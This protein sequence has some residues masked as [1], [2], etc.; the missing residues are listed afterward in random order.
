VLFSAGALASV[1]T[2]ASVR[3]GTA[4]MKRPSKLTLVQLFVLT[5]LAIAL[6][7]TTTFYSVLEWSR[8]SIVEQSDRLRDADARRIGSRV[9]A[10]LGV[11]AAA[12]EDV[13]SAIRLGALRTDDAAGVENRLFSELLAHPTLSDVA[14]THA[15]LLGRGPG[16]D[17]R[18]S[19]D[20]RWQTSVFRV[21]ADPASEI[22][23]R[24]ISM[25]Q[26]RFVADARRRARGAGLLGAPWKREPV[27]IDPTTHP[28]FETTVSQPLYG[29]SIWS[30]LS[31]SELDSTLPM[32]ERRVIV[33]VQKA[34]E[35]VPGHFVGVMRVGLLTQTIDNL[36]RIDT[37]ESQRVFLCDLKGRLVAR[38]DVVDAVQP[39]GD[40]LRVVSRRLPPETAAALESLRLLGLSEARPERSERLVVGGAPFLVTYRVLSTASGSRPKVRSASGS[41]RP[42]WPG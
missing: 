29:R 26:G 9:S 28:T 12:L 32:A 11:A 17:A 14:L 40:D 41:S 21:S 6:A 8:R 10:E 7:M 42:P 25:A 19:P 39:V 27:A 37:S 20:D 22:I 33:T 3:Q 23:T 5:T 1:I 36:P 24:R 15:T 16:G 35:D 30:D 2:S 34:V 18:W 13:A 38:P 4:S 31:F